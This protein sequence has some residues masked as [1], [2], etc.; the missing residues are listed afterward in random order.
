MIQLHNQQAEKVVLGSIL[1][2]PALLIEAKK[3]LTPAHFK[4]PNKQIYEAML[5]AE[6]NGDM[7]E[8]GTV[9]MLLYPEGFDITYLTDIIAL[10]SRQASGAIKLIYEAYMRREALNSLNSSIQLL[11]QGGDIFATLEKTRLALSLEPNLGNTKTLED[12]QAERFLELEQADGWYK[13]VPYMPT[14]FETLDRGTRG[15]D[16]KGG[17]LIVVGAESGTGKTTF[18]LQ[19]GLQAN[20][21]G[22]SG[23]FFSLEMKTGEIG[24]KLLAQRAGIDYDRVRIGKLTKEERI[25]MQSVIIQDDKQGQMYIDDTAGASLSYIQTQIQVMKKKFNI[26]Y[27]IIDYIQLISASGDMIKDERTKT[28]A[29]TRGLKRIAKEAEV[30]IIALSQLSRAVNSNLGGRP[31]LKDLKESGSTVE[32]ADVVALLYRPEK[33]N[34]EQMPN[35]ES[36]AGKTE[37]IIAK[38][39]HGKPFSF[40]TNFNT[41]GNTFVDAG[42]DGSMEIPFSHYNR[43]LL[44]AKK[45]DQA[46]QSLSD[47]LTGIE[48]LDFKQVETKPAP[49]I[50]PANPFEED[51][52]PF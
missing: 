43:G 2:T 1:I 44:Q 45:Y 20:E 51:V 30:C 16:Y 5:Q 33:H 14:G 8:L 29:I 6:I 12:V 19:M 23:A 32:D 26:T 17:H 49:A 42:F 7:P 35:G 40:W 46:E 27:V 38:N 22:H 31:M 18:T 52:M 39:R 34:I 47:H 21:L 25:K 3:L 15:L 9:S 24:S 28:V 10:N 50:L 41:N 4:G 36:S 11:M 13:E 37:V 48:D